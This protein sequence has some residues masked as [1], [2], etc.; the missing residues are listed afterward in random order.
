MSKTSKIVDFTT[1]E[2]LLEAQSSSRT[3]QKSTSY[4][5]SGVISSASFRLSSPG[6]P[7]QSTQQLPV[8]WSN[9]QN[10]VFFGSAAAIT[11]IAFDTIINRFP[12]D[13]TAT[14]IEDYFDSLSGFEKYIFGLFPKSLNALHFKDSYISV[15]D[16]AGSSLPLLSRNK[17]GAS[18]LDPGSSTI[19]FQT[20]IFLPQESQ[21]NQV[22]FQRFA[23]D[24][25]Y[26]AIVSQSNS[27]SASVLMAISSGTYW[28]TSSIEIPKGQWSDICFS[29]NRRPGVNRLQSFYN[30]V[31]KD[32]SDRISDAFSIPVTTRNLLIGS[33]T[34][35]NAGSLSLVPVSTLSA[36]LDDFKVFIGTRTSDSILTSVSSSQQPSDSLRLYF[37]FNEPTG[38]YT[39]NN[40]ALDSSGNGLHS[41]ITN[42]QLSLR[43]SASRSNG[44]SFF[45]ELPEYNPILFSDYSSIVDIN[46]ELLSSASVYDDNNPNLILNMIPRHYLTLGQAEQGFTQLDG[47]LDREFSDGGTLPRDTK[48]GPTQIMTAL[49]LTWARQFDDLKLFVDFFSKLDS[50]NYTGIDS[51]PATFLPYVAKQYGIELPRLFSNSNSEQYLKGTNLTDDPTIASSTLS[52]IESIIWRRIVSNLPYVMR[53]KGTIESIKSVIRSVGIDPD[54]AIRI[55]EYGGPTERFIDS[56]SRTKITRGI[57]TTGSFLISSPFLS[58]SRSEPGDPKFAGSIVNG[59]SDNP[60]DGL[61]T[62]GSW[63]FETFVKYDS[64]PST[65]ESI[66]RFYTSGSDEKSLLLNLI[67]VP[68]GSHRPE[69]A[70][71]VLSG[72]YSSN[73]SDSEPFG[74]ETDNIPLFNG[75][76]WFLS[77]SRDRID[78]STSEWHL[79]TSQGSNDKTSYVSDLTKKVIVD[80]QYDAFSTLGSS[81]NTSGS[82]FEIGTRAIT[83][84]ASS[85][86]LT[87]PAVDSFARTGKFTGRVGEIR[88]YS[89]FLDNHEWKEHALNPRSTGVRSPGVN[90]NFNVSESG[91]FER[92]RIDVNMNQIVTASNSSG[93]ISFFDFTQ[94]QFHLAGSGFVANSKVIFSDDEI[95]T[96]LDPKFD[97]SSVTNKVR[98]RSWQSDEYKDVYGGSYAPLTEVPRYETPNDDV[99]F[100]IEMSIVKGLNEDMASIFGG[101]IAIDDLF[102][103]TN[104]MFSD[105]YTNLRQVRDNYFNRLLGPV[106]AKDVILFARWFDTNISKLVEQLVPVTTNY[107]GTN[108]V[109][110]SHML[111]RNRIRYFWGDSYLLPSTRV[112]LRG[113]LG[114]SY[115]TGSLRKF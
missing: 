71:I 95:V 57:I 63:S 74:I 30:G 106:S 68:S 98:I 78:E 17:S 88:F 92:L 104:S 51:I 91:S 50:S 105:E 81:F 75:N 34:S 99:R 19:S 58:S 62:S 42:F 20:K 107:F 110:E 43:D 108:L 112:G 65:N 27:L 9:F 70:K 7:L 3:G 44:I 89:K 67:A 45:N 35:H 103:Q 94:N 102:G 4:S 26:T 86:F 84:L 12:F 55:R 49:L 114:L 60:S 97:E 96:I 23:N 111:E 80:P 101:N 82:Q 61:L 66:V 39:N 59:I 14:E 31:M 73:T 79:R 41:E 32:Q 22:I 24:C 1:I 100:G 5:K 15:V 38:S 64:V 90:F 37:K 25:G 13:G 85:R 21:D 76:K 36:S 11:N 46:T 48:L 47:E 115:L 10:F 40:L 53:S 6:M 29:F 72:C 52:Q 2:S 54:L 87:N 83:T 109:I 113:T 8:N 16:S 77:I 69:L 18:V 56:R 28:F 93:E 33:G